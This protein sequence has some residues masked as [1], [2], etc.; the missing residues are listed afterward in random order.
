MEP[1]GMIRR[2][3]ILESLVTTI[4]GAV[5]GLALLLT[6]GT[7]H[8]FSGEEAESMAGA[9][10]AVAH[11]YRTPNAAKVWIVT[12]TT[13]PNPGLL[14]KIDRGH[15]V[16]VLE[17]GIQH[18]GEWIRVETIDGK[19]TRGLAMAHLFVP[20]TDNQVRG[21]LHAEQATLEGAIRDAEA[22]RLR[23]AESADR[24]VQ[25]AIQLEAE[26]SAELARLSAPPSR[27]EPSG[28]RLAAAA[29]EAAV[30]T[31]KAHQPPRKHTG[32]RKPRRPTVTLAKAPKP[33]LPR[34]VLPVAEP[35][36]SAPAEIAVPA[37]TS[38]RPQTPSIPQDRQLAGAATPA[39][40]APAPAPDPPPAS[41]A[42]PPQPTVLAAAPA[43]PGP[44][45]A[46]GQAD[47]RAGIEAARALPSVAWGRILLVI[48]LLVGGA[49]G[50]IHLQERR[51]ERA[52]ELVT[53]STV[54]LTQD[55]SLSLVKAPGRTLVIGTTPGG[56]QLISDLESDLTPA[57][58]ARSFLRDHGLPE[59]TRAEPSTLGRLLGEPAGLDRVPR[60]ET[61]RRLAAASRRAF[62]SANGG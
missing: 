41:S 52:S 13:W 53:L 20:A 30:T 10:K 58:A 49:A 50:A 45:L 27:G 42:T 48:M 17:T 32:I 37:V 12:R 6:G 2:L 26:R 38:A 55:A 24:A 60:T 44:V 21:A 31:M 19:R 22:E 39:H 7:A 28:L 8:A 35:G 40:A 61:E 5:L 3:P 51:K 56:V 18:H 4:C 46:I 9:Q 1:T 23:L 57:T 29:F 36:T 47:P 15:V 14:R 59:A 25:E 62:S 11:S 33:G 43:A 34:A 16:R 54:P